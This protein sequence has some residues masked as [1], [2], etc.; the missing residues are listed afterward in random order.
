MNIAKRS[1]VAA[2]IAAAVAGSPAGSVERK[3]A[4]RD[5]LE[6]CGGVVR[7]DDALRVKAVREST[8]EVDFVASTGTLDAHYEVIDQDSWQL[9]DYQANPVVLYGHNA[10]DL[11][12]GQCTYVALRNGQLECTI[13]FASAEANPEA[14]KVWRLVKEKVLRAVSVGFRPVNGAYEMIDGDSVWVWRNAIL[15]EIS[16]VAIPANPDALAKMKA[17]TP[18]ARGKNDPPA[19]VPANPETQPTTKGTDDM[20]TAEQLAKEL[21]DKTAA[22]AETTTKL[23]AVNVKLVEAEALAEKSHAARLVAEKSLRDSEEKVKSLEAAAR[24]LEA[25]HAKACTDRDAAKKTVDELD[26]KLVEVE[27]ESVV[28]VKIAPAE[29]EEFVE[30]R[31]SNPALYKKMVDKRP[32]M[33]LTKRVTVDD[34]TANGKGEGAHTAPPATLNGGGAAAAAGFN[35]L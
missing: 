35:D 19:G 29:K 28:G 9:E 26:A 7:K 13:M 24:T 16:V 2:V 5:A 23:T 4:F 14:E 6:A 11:P 34:A 25:E 33:G 22:H 3:D 31:R 8:R 17:A 10:W 32:D 30:L 18:P 21:E 20:K 15:K 1:T 12:I 27:V